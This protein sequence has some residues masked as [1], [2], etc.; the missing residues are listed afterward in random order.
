MN[1]RIENLREVSKQC[2]GR[3]CKV[4]R[5]NTSGVTG[6]SFAKERNKWF[7]QIYTPEKKYTIG[8]FDTLLDAV[9]ARW[10]KEV[11]LNW[12]GCNSTSSAYLYLQSIGD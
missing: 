2:N 1:N 9:R 8:Y 7:A 10:K 3:N 4:S 5:R 6:V 11:E 12:N